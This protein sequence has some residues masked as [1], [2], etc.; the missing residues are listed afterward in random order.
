[1]RWF[2]DDAPIRQLA[3]EAALP[4]S[5]SYRYLH[6]AIDVIAE[7][8]PDVH[9]VL[10]RAKREQWSQVT[11]DETLI[12]I[13]RINERNEARNHRWYSGKHKTQGG[14]VQILADP[15]GFPVWSSEVEPGSVHDITA[16]RAHCLGALYKAA[17]DRVPTLADKGYAGAG[18][19]VHTPVKGR[20]LD[21]ENQSY[22]MLLA[23]VRAIGERANA[24]L[25]QRWRCLRRIRLCPNRISAVVAAAIVLSTLQRGN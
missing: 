4:I 12:A 20:D 19:G 25:K 16:A 10:D 1:L 15:G 2:G 6:E 18:I 21:R 9:E 5:T 11:W 23:A 8:A 24:E 14:N 22:N 7:Q 17:A 13:D 3:T